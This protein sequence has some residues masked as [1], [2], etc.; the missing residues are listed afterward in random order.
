MPNFAKVRWTI[1]DIWPI[2]NFSRWRPSAIL[3]F[4][5]LEN[6]NFQ[7]HSK[8]QYASSYQILRESMK[9]FRR[10]GR[11]TIFQDGGRRHLGF[12]KF[13]IFNGWHAQEGRNASACQILSKSIK[14]GL[15][16]GDLSIFHD[17]GRPPCWIFKSWKFQLPVPLRGP[18]CVTDPNFAKIGRT[19]PEI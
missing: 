3:D 10:Y 19:V 16:Y 2:F 5:N 4:Q 1:P 18:I 13:Q 15:R 9:P 11:F 12:W 8:D 17:G 7:S 6:F 14:S